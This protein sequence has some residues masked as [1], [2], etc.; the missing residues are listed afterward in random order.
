MIAI[1]WKFNISPV[2]KNKKLFL[3]LHISLHGIQVHE[4]D[5]NK[6]PR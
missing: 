2:L 4:D 3:Y 6:Y 5:T 1:L